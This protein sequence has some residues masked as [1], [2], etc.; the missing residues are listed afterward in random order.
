VPVEHGYDVGLW[1]VMTTTGLALGGVDL[2]TAAL[3]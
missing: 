2:P 3:S 1:L